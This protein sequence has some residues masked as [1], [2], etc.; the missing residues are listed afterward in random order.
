MPFIYITFSFF[1]G[2]NILQELGTLSQANPS[3]LS[4]S[5]PFFFSIDADEFIYF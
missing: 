2:K 5:I 4:I 3:H 1:A